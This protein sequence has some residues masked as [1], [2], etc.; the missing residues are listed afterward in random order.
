[1]PGYR[2]FVT[3][4]FQYQNRKKGGNCG[5]AKVEVRQE[6]CRIELQVK[7]Y[8]EKQFPVYLFARE[9]EQLK[10]IYL[11]ELAVKNGTGRAAF[12]ITADD[13]AGTPYGIDD[14]RGLYLAGDGSNFIASQWDDADTVWNT[15]SP[16]KKTQEEINGGDSEIQDNGEK[17]NNIEENLEKEEHK[18]ASDKENILFSDEKKAEGSVDKRKEE[19]RNVSEKNTEEKNVSE[20]NTEGKNMSEKNAEEKNMGEKNAEEKNMGEKNAEEKNMGEKNTGEK[21]MSEKDVKERNENNDIQTDMIKAS[22]QEERQPELSATQAASA[23]A[24]QPYRFLHTW[25]QQWQRFIAA[26]PVFCPFDE[27]EG[28]Y[29]VKMELRDFKILPRQYWYLANN[30][31]LLHGYFNYRYVLFGYMDGEQKRWFIGIPGIFQNQEQIL[32]GAF[33][34]P[35]FRTKQLTRQKTGEFGYWYRCLDLGV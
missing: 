35:E 17:R 12:V 25:E 3:Y 14:M 33:G 11:G 10:G 31:F 28:V 22:P 32:A 21:D 29:G 24:A 13:I 16:H 2:R 1:M 20:K 23:T 5:F 4:L 26:H 27:D 34:F 6:R 15:F 7:S 30:S 19:W 9:E 18:A 8:E